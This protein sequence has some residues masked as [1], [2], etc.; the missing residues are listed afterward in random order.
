MPTNQEITLQLEDRPGTLANICSAMADRGVNIMAI[1]ATPEAGKS[2]VR[3]VVDNS[4]VAKAVL[5]SQHRLLSRP[6]RSGD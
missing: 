6:P 1:Q 2:R 5:N 3:F 4:S